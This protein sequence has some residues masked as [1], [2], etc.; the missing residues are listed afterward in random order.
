[1]VPVDS[2]GVSP[3]PPYSGARYLISTNLYGGVTLYAASSQKLP[4]RLNSDI[5]SP[6]TPKHL[7]TQVWA[8]PLSLATT[9]GITNLFSSPPGT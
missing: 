1:M 2:N 9:R 5:A 6:T 7:R 3:A 4:V 8:R